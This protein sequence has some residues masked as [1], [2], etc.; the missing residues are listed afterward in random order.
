M[1]VTFAQFLSLRVGLHSFLLQLNFG[2]EWSN[3]A[4][5]T[6]FLS[7]G[8]AH[9]YSHQETLGVLNF[10]LNDRPELLDQQRETETLLLGLLD[11]RSEQL[12]T[13]FQQL[14]Q[15]LVLHFQRFH[16]VN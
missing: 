9:I 10:L 7:R 8:H 11:L 4:G 2:Y 3:G 13:I 16:L 12:L 1:S 5:L 6:G 14:H 15:L